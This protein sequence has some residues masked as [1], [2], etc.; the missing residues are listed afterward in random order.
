MFSTLFLVDLLE[1]VLDPQRPQL[2]NSDG[3]ALEC[4]VLVYRLRSGVTQAK[5]RAALNQAPELDA[6]SPTFWNWLAPKGAGP[7]QEPRRKGKA[8]SYT[9]T[10]DD[11][12]MVLGTVELKAKTVEVHVNSEGRA[13]RGRAMIAAVLGDLVGAPLMQRQTIEQA[14]AERSDHGSAPE[15][16]GLTAEEE[17]QAVHAALDQHYRR[18]LDEPVPVLGNISP[19]RAARSAKGREKLVAWLKL[20]EN[21]ATRHEPA[22]PMASY[23]L[24][25]IWR[26]L[27]IAE[28]RK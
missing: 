7:K 23:D 10:M 20:L 1:R 16:S 13:E 27:D 8:L 21:H 15:P 6:A 28:L 5:I 3:E 14:L 19:R 2:A 24:S 18:Q 4:I 17:R 26:E 22:E 12:S 11:G 25:W 9:S